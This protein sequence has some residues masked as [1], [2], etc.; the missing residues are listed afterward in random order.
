MPCMTPPLWCL[1]NN[2]HVRVVEQHPFIDDGKP[3]DIISPDPDGYDTIS[4]IIEIQAE[5]ADQNW[6]LNIPKA[7][8]VVHIKSTSQNTKGY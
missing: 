8:L 7:G 6:S 5:L 4:V 1:A 3:L 2:C